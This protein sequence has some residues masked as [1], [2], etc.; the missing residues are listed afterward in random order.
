MSDHK[1]KIPVEEGLWTNPPSPGDKPQLIGSKCRSC[2]EIFFP[3]KK[4]IICIH[5]QQRKLEDVKLSGKG[6]IASF[7]VVER[8]P[9]GGYYK[10]PVPYA[11]GAVNMLENV[12]L[13][14][15]FT[16]NLDDLRVGMDVE[17]VIDKLSNDVEGNEI[18]T[19]QFAP[20]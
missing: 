13:F 17:M 5:C 14:T 9:A 15:L 20:I 19:Y 1:K 11:Y 3:R 16:G 2:G 18:V 12:Q 8:A 4:K 10:G 7:A 6:K